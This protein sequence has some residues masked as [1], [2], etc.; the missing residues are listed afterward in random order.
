M[1]IAGAIINATVKGVTS[2]QSNKIKV[3]A[4]KNAAKNIKNITEET[5]GQK[6]LEKQIQ[7]GLDTAYDIGSAMGNELS[8]IQ[9]QPTAPGTTTA[10]NS[11]EAYK[12]AMNAGQGALDAANKGMSQGMAN[13][14]TLNQAEY[15]AEK[16]KQDLALQ[17]ADIDYKVAQQTAQEGINAAGD[18]A[19]TVAS[20]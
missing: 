17:Q 12:N 4:Y 11:A 18:I 15:N 8:A 10:G 5:S 14:S 1:A 13:Q 20:I 9:T 16:A 19:K 3:E 6:G 2:A 7:T